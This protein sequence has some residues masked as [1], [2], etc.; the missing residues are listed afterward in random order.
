MA[1]SQYYPATSPSGVPVIVNGIEVQTGDLVLLGKT[2]GLAD[3]RVLAELLRLAPFVNSG[4][5]S[6]KIIL[7]YDIM[8][9]PATPGTVQ[10]GTGGVFVFPF[11]AVVGSR[12]PIASDAKAS[13]R[14]I[15][16]GVF[17]ASTTALS[18]Q[19]L[20]SANSSGGT[21]WDLIYARVDVDVAS[22]SVQRRVKD[23]NAA[24][25]SVQAVFQ[26]LEQVVTVGVVAGSVANTV[27]SPPID[28]VGV[29]YY[30]T[31]AAVRKPNGF[32]GSSVVATTDIRDLAP[33][34]PLARSTGAMTVRPGNGN[35]DGAGTY[36]TNFPW[37]SGGG[38]PPVFLPPSM[39]GSESI[40]VE[41]DVSN[42]TAP[43]HRNGDVVDSTVDWRNR[44]FAI[45]ATISTDALKFANDSSTSGVSIPFGQ[46]F[47]NSSQLITPDFRMANSFVAD[48]T[49]GAGTAL[50]YEATNSLF[51][52]IVASG[53]LGIY[54]DMATGVMKA[55]LSG[56]P[57][58]NVRVLLWLM[59]TAQFP[60]V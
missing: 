15:R 3:D 8:S 52:N 26:T 46:Y 13:W 45:F 2:A 53:T 6:P 41:F 48:A 36:A 54:V 37:S 40:L 10:P 31:L 33:T 44:F 59:A 14:D 5:L 55:F 50:I 19:L 42:G 1:E 23:P 7:P 9:S 58:N 60:N 30:I 22:N 21:L 47:T 17:T 38:R 24:N 49:L 27:P 32:N 11:R 51:H 34:A 56:T 4:S 35:H 20:L 12:T 43:S 57:P 28:V 18:E 16:T 29:T 25:P 39:V